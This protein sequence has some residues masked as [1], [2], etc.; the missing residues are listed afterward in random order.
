MLTAKDSKSNAHLKLWGE[1][2]GSQVG[3]AV[4]QELIRLKQL[5]QLTFKRFYTWYESLSFAFR[6]FVL[7]SCYSSVLIF[8]HAFLFWLLARLSI[9][10]WTPTRVRRTH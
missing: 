3:E 6:T 2:V 4:I 5:D 10:F 9:W 8:N 1:N 7:P